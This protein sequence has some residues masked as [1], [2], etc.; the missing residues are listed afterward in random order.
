MKTEKYVPLPIDELLDLLSKNWGVPYGAE[1]Q[2]NAYVEHL[3]GALKDAVSSLE[4]LANHR[5]QDGDNLEADRNEM[6]GYAASRAR[7][8]HEALT[9]E[10]PAS[11]EDEDPT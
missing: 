2:V 11:E 7:A 10:P 8:A 1:A 5:P 3:R 9:T 4:W 6:R